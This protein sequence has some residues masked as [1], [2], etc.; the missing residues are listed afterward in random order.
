[1]EAQVT[2]ANPGATPSPE[3]TRCPLTVN[4][5]TPQLKYGTRSSPLVR[6]LVLVRL[7]NSSLL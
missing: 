6:A 2:I 3:S 5:D 1:M 7:G 4:N